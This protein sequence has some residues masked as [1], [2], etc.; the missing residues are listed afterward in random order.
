MDYVTKENLK[1][2][3]WNELHELLDKKEKELEAAL[4]EPIEYYSPGYSDTYHA[5]IFQMNRH[6]GI[7]KDIDL[8]WVAINEISKHSTTEKS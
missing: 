6:N 8:I 4:E 7:R 2:L 5:S 3:S 1:T